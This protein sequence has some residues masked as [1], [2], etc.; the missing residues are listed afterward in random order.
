MLRREKWSTSYKG[1]SCQEKIFKDRRWES[2]GTLTNEPGDS[3]ILK[4]KEKD[5]LGKGILG[6]ICGLGFTTIVVARFP[7]CVK[8]PAPLIYSKFIYKVR[9][10]Q[11]PRIRHDA[12]TILCHKI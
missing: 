1:I 4:I 3:K 5:N 10:K 9:K 7:N 6:V 12:M 11:R 8:N 2:Y